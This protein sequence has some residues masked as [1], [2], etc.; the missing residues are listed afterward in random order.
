MAPYNSWL[1]WNP[2][3]P[4]CPG[5]GPGHQRAQNPTLHTKG[6]AHLWNTLGPCPITCEL[7]LTP[8]PPGLETPGHGPTSSS[9][10]P[11]TPQSAMT[12]PTLPTRSPPLIMTQRLP[13]IRWYRPRFPRPISSHAN[14]WPH[15][16]QQTASTQDRAWQ[17]TE[18]RV[19]LV[20]LSHNSRGAHADHIRGTSTAYISGER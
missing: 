6:T 8:G 13:P 9:K 17:P 10:T 16:P 14:T 15:Q 3:D 19:R 5:T 11:W 20:G 12:K 18:T 7:T 1:P 2:Y 4:S